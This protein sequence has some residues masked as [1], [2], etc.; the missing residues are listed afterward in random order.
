[1]GWQ[2]YYYIF[3]TEEEKQ[4][5][6]DL[7]EAHNAETNWDIVGEPLDGVC[8]RELKRCTPRGKK[9][10]LFGH[11]GGRWSTFK[12]FE[13]RGVSLGGYTCAFGERLRECD[14]SQS[15]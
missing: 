11:G 3:D 12:Y 8:V 5:V 14:H 4:K 13:D 2:S 10:L 9:V 6:L 15:K 1:M 7:I